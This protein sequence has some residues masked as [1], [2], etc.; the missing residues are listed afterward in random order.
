M[1]PNKL[2]PKQQKFCELYTCD[3]DCFGNGFRSYVKAYGI[4]ATKRGASAGARA[5]ASQ[6]LTNPNILAKINEL[7][8]PMKMTDQIVDQELSFL[9]AQRADY[10]VK[11]RAISEY[12]KLRGRISQ[13]LQIERPLED[14][15]DEELEAIIAEGRKVFAK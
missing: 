13:K 15:S 10:G 7:A 8:E 2:T 12:N 5:S 14:M 4:D 1:K 9:I 11:I 6:L 3:P